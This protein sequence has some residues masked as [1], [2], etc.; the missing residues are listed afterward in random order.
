[1]LRAGESSAA[2]STHRSAEDPAAF[3]PWDSHQVDHNPPQLH[4]KGAGTFLWHGGRRHA[5]SAHPHMQAFLFPF[6]F[7]MGTLL[8]W[9]S[10]ARPAVRHL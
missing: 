5:C 1:M 8:R 3:S 10:G 7:K 6:F 9:K 4:I 2:K